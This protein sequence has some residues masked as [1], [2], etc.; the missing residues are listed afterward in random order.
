MPVGVIYERHRESGHLANR[1][2]TR[3]FLPLLL[4]IPTRARSPRHP[5]RHDTYGPVVCDPGA[6]LPI[7]VDALAGSWF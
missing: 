5:L 2:G 7:C 4:I 6:T 3:A 1:P